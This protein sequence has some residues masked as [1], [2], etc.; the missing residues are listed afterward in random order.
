LFKIHWDDDDKV[1]ELA[2]EVKLLK[3]QMKEKKKPPAKAKEE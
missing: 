1:A 2:A 3:E